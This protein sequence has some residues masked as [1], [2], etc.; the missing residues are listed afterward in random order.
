MYGYELIEKLTDK[1]REVELVGLRADITTMKGLGE[2]LEWVADKGEDAAKLTV[3]LL[4]PN[5]IHDDSSGDEFLDLINVES[6]RTDYEGDL[7]SYG[8]LMSRALTVTVYDGPGAGLGTKVSDVLADDIAT[9]FENGYLD[10]GDARATVEEK[11]IDEDWDD[12]IR[13]DVP[14]NANARNLLDELTTDKA[15]AVY[16]HALEEMAELDNWTPEFEGDSL[17]INLERL[18]ELMTIHLE[19]DVRKV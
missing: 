3:E 13:Y 17:L 15:K 6:L 2:F 1:G 11:L 12:W 16:F 19:T 10:D 5:T 18:A 7:S 4:L 14:L 8:L 9:L